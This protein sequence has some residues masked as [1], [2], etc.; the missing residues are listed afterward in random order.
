MAQQTKPIIVLVDD[1]PQVLDA[2]KR[3]LHKDFQVV[4][5]TSPLEALPWIRQQPLVTI[6]VSDY[7][8]PSENG[9]EFL[10]KCKIVSPY[11]VR[12]IL[13]GQIEL[14][15]MVLAINKAE[16]HRFFLKPWENN[17]LKLQFIEC[18]QLHQELIEKQYLQTLA[19]TDPL[20]GLFNHRHFQS[21]IREKLTL[22]KSK[23]IKRMA[24]LM[25]DV[26]HFKQFNDEFGHPE[27]DRMLTYLAQFIENQIG[28]KGIVFRYGGEEFSIIIPDRDYHCVQSL[29]DKLRAAIEARKWTGPNAK[30]IL[31]TVSIGVSY[32]EEFSFTAEDLISAADR[33]LYQAKR[34][35]RNQFVASILK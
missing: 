32:T 10:R 2:L 5:F 21:Q 24:L 27:G 11:S 31:S 33:N 17:Y 23:I 15:E 22:L 9:I 30:T 28:E 35:G 34:Q 19:I 4:V 20:T 6:I 7:K 12:V 29:T 16:I 18:L 3:T 13:S 8:M 26:D 25:L 1:D 14:E